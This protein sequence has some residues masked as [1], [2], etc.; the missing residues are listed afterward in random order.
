MFALQTRDLSHIDL[1]RSDNISNLSAAKA[2]L[3]TE[4]MIIT[5]IL[6]VYVMKVVNKIK[7]AET[8]ESAEHE[9]EAR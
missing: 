6:L 9:S 3:S 2:Y 5:L 1:S 8:K 4:S 7:K